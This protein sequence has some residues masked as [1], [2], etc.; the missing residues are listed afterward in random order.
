MNTHL[1]DLEVY[2]WRGDLHFLEDMRK[3][4]YDFLVTQG[5]DPATVLIQGLVTKNHDRIRVEV[6]VME[7]EEGYFHES[8]IIHDDGTIMT[9]WMMVS[10][11]P[12][13]HLL[14]QVG[15]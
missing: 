10:E 8:P 4:G 13:A 3:E 12:P 2:R 11:L 7:K 1:D 5:I 9:T 15:A 6:M 14:N